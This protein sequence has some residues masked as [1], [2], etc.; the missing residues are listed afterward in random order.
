MIALSMGIGHPREA[1]QPGELVKFL[2]ELHFLRWRIVVGAFE[3]NAN[4][5]LL[6]DAPSFA[7]VDQ[8]RQMKTVS[9]MI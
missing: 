8:L 1:E 5:F 6:R 2:P 3:F 4:V 9:K 7:S